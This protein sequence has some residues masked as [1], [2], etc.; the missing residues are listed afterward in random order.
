MIEGSFYKNIDKI[1]SILIQNGYANLSK[2]LAN[3]AHGNMM[4][5]EVLGETEI[6]LKEIRLKIN[7][8][9]E[10]D[11]DIDH[12]LKFIDKSFKDIGDR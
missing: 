12:L 10:L 5:S 9:E 4:A 8:N 11:I 6:V 1:C 3:A 2:D 7:D